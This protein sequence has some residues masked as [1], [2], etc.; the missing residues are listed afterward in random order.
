[1]YSIIT[2]FIA[3]KVIDIVIEGLDESK[4]AWVISDKADLIG[5]AIIARLGKEVFTY[6]HGE[7]G[8]YG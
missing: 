2:Y 6:L 3:F 1:M 5:N 7:G 8:V 4:S